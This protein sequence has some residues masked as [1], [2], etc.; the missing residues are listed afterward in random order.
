MQFE[1]STLELL[2][3]LCPGLAGRHLLPALPA[4]SFAKKSRKEFDQSAC[5]REKFDKPSSPLCTTSTKCGTPQ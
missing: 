5:L 2:P 1:V 4:T 3:N